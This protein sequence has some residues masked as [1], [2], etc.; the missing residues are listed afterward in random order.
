MRADL[1]NGRETLELGIPKACA[2]YSE[3]ETYAFF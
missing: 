2:F 3:G 1:P